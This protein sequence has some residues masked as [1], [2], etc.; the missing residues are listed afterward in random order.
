M[1]TW[2]FPRISSLSS[3][4]SLLIR[5]L[6]TDTFISSQL[7]R[8]PGWTKVEHVVELRKGWKL[9]R[10][11]VTDWQQIWWTIYPYI[12]YA[13]KNLLETSSFFPEEELRSLLICASYK[14][15]EKLLEFPGSGQLAAPSCFLHTSPGSSH[16]LQLQLHISWILHIWIL[17][18]LPTEQSKEAMC[19]SC[20]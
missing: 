9:E 2:S 16:I 11:D 12:Y 1:S 10:E 15:M 18:I 6:K 20:L 8:V 3:V 4:V 19:P 17:H 13:R 7:Q 5:V 14:A